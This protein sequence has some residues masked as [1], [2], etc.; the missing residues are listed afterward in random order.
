MKDW[1]DK[2]FNR[3]PEAPDEREIRPE[4]FKQPINP[5]ATVGSMVL[6][7]LMVSTAMILIYWYIATVRGGGDMFNLIFLLVWIF[8]M[9]PIYLMYNRYQQHQEKIETN[10]L[11][12]K[13]RNYE[14]TGLLCSLYD[15]HVAANYTPCDGIDWQPLPGYS[16]DQDDQD[17]VTP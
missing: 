11:C 17:E 1:I 5:S 3:R 9:Y 10:S 7:G 16:R 4:L 2:F 15:E 13:C 6:Y 12:A 8:A 14:E